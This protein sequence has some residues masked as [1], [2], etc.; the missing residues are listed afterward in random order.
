MGHD[1]GVAHQDVEVG[2]LGD[3][4]LG[5]SYGGGEGC[6]VAFE[7]YDFCFG[8]AGADCGDDSFGACCIAPADVDLRGVVFREVDG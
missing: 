3:E 7:E 5:R 6:E 2:C 1:A 4:V 8:A